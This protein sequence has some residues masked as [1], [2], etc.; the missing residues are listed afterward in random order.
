MLV[1][2]GSFGEGG[3]Q[4]LRTSLTVAAATG[5][6]FRINRIRANRQ[7]PGLRRQHLAAVEAAAVVCGAR[8]RGAT[9]GSHELEFQPGRVRGGEWSFRV[10]SAGSACLVLQTVLLPLLT[11]PEPSLF[12]VEGG[13]H[14]P[15]APPFEF[16]D[17]AYLPLLRRMGARVHAELVRHGFAPRGGG[18]VDVR[19]DPVP[20]LESLDLR[21]RGAVLECRGRALLSGLPDR[22]GERELAFVGRELGWPAEWLEIERIEA[23]G[24]GNALVLEVCSEHVSE[25]FSAFGERGLPAEAVAAR[26]AE[27]VRDYLAA[28]VPVGPH[29]A[30][31][32]LLPLAL[33]GGGRFATIRPTLHFVTNREVLQRFLGTPI[34]VRAVDG[35]TEVDVASS[36]WSTG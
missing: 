19:I 5:T 9:L 4:I 13:T 29:L 26:A 36:A 32:L 22:I 25:A 14:N 16:L 7:R 27:A 20:A 33:A 1:I 8:V 15:G 11:A 28:A 17:R 10:G 24:P 30:D 18:R 3:G 2:D 34:Q 35:T 23:A 6:P 12:S 21:A 31:Q